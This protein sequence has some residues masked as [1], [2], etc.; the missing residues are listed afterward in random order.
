MSSPTDEASKD[1]DGTR[2]QNKM[3]YTGMNERTKGYAHKA[4]YGPWEYAPPDKLVTGYKI[5]RLHRPKR[6][7]KINN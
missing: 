7:N 2:I 1:G 5:N 6:G 4:F 3:H